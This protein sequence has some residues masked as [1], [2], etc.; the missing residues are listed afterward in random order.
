MVQGLNGEQA[1]KRFKQ[2]F[3][4]VSVSTD[5]DT[6]VDGFAKHVSYVSSGPAG[7]SSG[8]ST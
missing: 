6:L 1:E 3:D 5:I 4:M 7:A 2:G 8:Y